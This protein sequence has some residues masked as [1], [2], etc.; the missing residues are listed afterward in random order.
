MFLEKK[1]YVIEYYG[2]VNEKKILSF[3]FLYEI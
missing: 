3:N 2:I 1:D